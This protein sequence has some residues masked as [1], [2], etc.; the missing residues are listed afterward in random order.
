[1]KLTFFFL[2]LAGW[3]QTA[4]HRV[5]PVLI[6]NEHNELMEFALD[7]GGNLRSVTCQFRGEGAL[8]AVEI[9]SMPD[10][11]VF[12]SAKPARAVTFRGDMPAGKGVFWLS[13]RVKANAPLSGRVSGWCDSVTTTNGEAAIRGATPAVSRRIGVAL[14]KH[15]DGGV[16]TYRIPAL[17][18]SPK[19]TLLAVYDMRRRKPRDLQ[20]D[21]DIGLSRSSDGGRT[22]E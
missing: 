3:A 5:H 17:A 9:V 8:E 13:A 7:G 18:T 20:E 12:A 14:R 11:R 4:V 16:D 22:W 19:G 6:R 21:I 1:M 15:G 2:T 10:K